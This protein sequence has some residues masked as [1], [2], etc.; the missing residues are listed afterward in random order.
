VARTHQKRGVPATYTAFEEE[1]ARTMSNRKQPEM[2]RD[3][4]A[5]DSVLFANDSFLSLEPDKAQFVY[6]AHE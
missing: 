4:G 5:T 1:G 3:E 6:N 2:M